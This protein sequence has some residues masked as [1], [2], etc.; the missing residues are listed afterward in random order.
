MKLYTTFFALL[1]VASACAQI[2]E[3]VSFSGYGNI[4]LGY[5]YKSV[6]SILDD[7][8]AH[9]DYY[10]QKENEYYM[11]KEGLKEDDFDDTPNAYYIKPGLA[12]YSEIFGVKVSKTEVIFDVNDKVVQILL[13]IPKSNETKFKLIQQAENRFGKGGCDLLE[14]KFYCA[15]NDSVRIYDYE[16][17]GDVIYN[18][19]IYI[20]FSKGDY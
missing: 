8:E 7:E 5:S 11:Q 20:R 3:H 17:R 19:Y 12:A 18:E 6:K 10:T 2:N 9:V 4:A 14:G 15:W 13:F 16:E 1:F